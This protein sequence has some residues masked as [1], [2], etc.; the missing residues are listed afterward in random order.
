MEKPVANK[1][2]YTV[3]LCA[4]FD[5]IAHAEMTAVEGA[6]QEG[7][8]AVGADLMEPGWRRLDAMPVHRQDCGAGL[9]VRLG[10]PRT[11]VLS[12]AP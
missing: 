5:L 1:R 7:A 12:T 10:S 2:F 11:G 3:M 8:G 9:A 4:P 6:R